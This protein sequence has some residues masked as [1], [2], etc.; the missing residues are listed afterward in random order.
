MVGKSERIKEVVEE[1]ATELSQVNE[2]LKEQLDR[3]TAQADVA[4]AI[5]KSEAI[6]AKVQDSAEALT[7]V[8]EALVGEVRERQLLEHQLEASRAQ[9]HAARDAAF[10]DPLTTLANRLLFSDRLEHGLA[11]AKRHG[12]TIAVMFIDLDAFKVVNDTHGH[13]VGDAV[14]KTIAARLQKMTREDDTVSRHGGDEFLYL[15]LELKSIA[16]AAAIAKKIIETLGQPCDG[17][18]DGVPALSVKPSVGIAL[19]PS[20]AQTAD[21][22]VNCADKAMYRAKRDRSGFAFAADLDERP[23]MT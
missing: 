15:L 3:P 23:A 21:D 13:E 8:N 2:V 20:D 17:L 18:G 10:H 12:W 16:D 14:L 7:K 6:E 11:Q 19:Y 1:C 5:Q 4:S 22:L 9:E